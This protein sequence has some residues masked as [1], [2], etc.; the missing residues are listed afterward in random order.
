MDDIMP[1]YEIRLHGHIDARRARQFAGLTLT[2]LPE[3]ETL[4]T[5]PVVDQAALYGILARIR[6][7]GMPLIEVKRLPLSPEFSQ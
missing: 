7:M 2:L 3:G 5:G 4:L 6:D 1:V